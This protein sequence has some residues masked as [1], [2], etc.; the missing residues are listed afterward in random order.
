V[1]S[2]KY[3]NKDTDILLDDKNVLKVIERLF[4]KNEIVKEKIYKLE[5]ISIRR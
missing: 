4:E 5:Y 2:I 3:Y 1:T